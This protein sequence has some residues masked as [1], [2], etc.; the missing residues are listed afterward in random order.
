[1]SLSKPNK[2][3]FVTTEK[4]QYW[5][6]R[7]NKKVFKNTISSPRNII[8]EET[9]KWEWGWCLTP[10]D[11]TTDWWDLYLM[12]RY[13]SFT[14]FLEILAHEMVHGW[15]YCKDPESYVK[16]KTHHGR[17]FFEWREPFKKVGIH[18][19]KNAY[20]DPKSNSE[21]MQKAI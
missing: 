13:P 18:L 2:P 19:S 17:D 14:L 6:K 12:R 16:S 7:L 10:P 5:F 15:L 21:K 1:M 20:E 3:Y 11:N 8:L 4:V 9:Y